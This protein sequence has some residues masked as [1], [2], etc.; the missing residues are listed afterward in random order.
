MKLALYFTFPYPS[1]ERFGK[2]MEIIS[3]VKFEYAELGIPT[4]Y[5]Y[6]DGPQIR[7][8]HGVA[9]KEF[10][11]ESLGK[12]VS[13]LKSQGKK[14]YAL[15]YCNLFSEN[16]GDFMEKLSAAGIDGIILPDLLTD[17]Y[18]ERIE[19]IHSVHDHGL[20]AIPFFNASTPDHSIEE[21]LSI[22]HSWIYFG[23]QPSTG[24]KVPLRID[25][26]YKRIRSLCGSRE[27]IVGF[28][29]DGPEMISEL[30]TAGFDGIAVGS[31][32]IRSMDEDNIS[33][34]EKQAKML[35]AETH[36]K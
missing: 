26:M 14:V 34:F 17:F 22:T 15:A 31:A 7:K 25:E 2:Y 27:I 16:P 13:I 11:M 33:A 36:G 12:Q 32:F 29:I 21:I 4:K 1:L 35:E 3:D 8:T 24:I 20:E 18:H 5:P 30:K 28:G 9:L 10:S 6:Y 19:I 23:L